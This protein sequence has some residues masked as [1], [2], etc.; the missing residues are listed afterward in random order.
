MIF[1]EVSQLLFTYFYFLLFTFAFYQPPSIH[2]LATP[3]F[4]TPSFR[5]AP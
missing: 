5:A 1:A 2:T 4:N 3:F